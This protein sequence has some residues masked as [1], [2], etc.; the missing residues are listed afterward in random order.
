MHKN[1]LGAMPPN[2]LS[3]KTRGGGG[4]GGGVTYQAP[5]PPPRG[6]C[7]LLHCAVCVCVCV[8]VRHLQSICSRERLS[9]VLKKPCYFSF[10]VKH[11]PQGPPTA[12]HCQTPTATNR[13]PPNATNH[14]PA[15]TAANH[16]QPPSTAT[17]RQP[18][19]E[20]YFIWHFCHGRNVGSVRVCHTLR[21]K[22]R[23]PVLPCSSHGVF[24]DCCSCAL[25]LYCWSPRV[26]RVRALRQGTLPR[27]ARCRRSPSSVQKGGRGG[28]HVGWDV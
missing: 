26:F 4:L 22:E 16:H 18:S 13:Q 24:T 20:T 14:R 6:A 3:L 28:L 9:G 1:K 2:P 27:A 15:P 5:G 12:K 7:T 19:T 17:N 25:V 8:Y 11:S 23:H 10:F 21:Q